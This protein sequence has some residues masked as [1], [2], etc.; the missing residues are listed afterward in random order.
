MNPRRTPHHC[1]IALALAFAYAAPARALPAMQD[2]WRLTCGGKKSA[3]PLDGACKQNGAEKKR[4]EAA[5]AKFQE[6]GGKG[7]PPQ[8]DHRQSLAAV[9]AI[10]QSL[11][12]KVKQSKTDAKANYWL[13]LALGL[14]GDE[15]AVNKLDD[16]I[17]NSKD[18]VL[19]AKAELAMAEFLF[20][21]KGPAAALDGYKKVM[22][23]KDPG[24]ALY[25]RYK[26]AWVDYAT[27]V[28]NKNPALKK[29]ALTSLA[30]V[31][32]DANSGTKKKK[33]KSDDDDEEEDD[34]GGTDPFAT[35]LAKVVKDDILNL[36]I[37]YGNPADVQAI[38]KSVNASD[39]YATFLERAAYVKWEAN[40][41][42]EAYKMFAAAIK[43]QVQ[44][45]KARNVQLNLNLAQIA[46][47]MNNIPLLVQ[48]LKIIQKTFLAGKAPWRKKQKPADLKKVDKQLEGSFF[49]YCAALDQ[50][51][52]KD[53]SP[54]SLAAADELY[55]LFIASFPKSPKAYEARFY[56]G[57]ILFLEKNYLKSAQSLI[58]MINQNPKGKFTKDGLDVM[59][60][61]AQLVTDADK[62]K[63]DVPKMGSIK[64]PRDIPSLRKV[65]A[66]A[67][68]LYVK[69][70]PKT[71]KTPAMKFVAA[72][73]YYDYGHYK[74]AIKTYWA[75]VQTYSADPMAKQAAQRLL[76]YYKLQKNDKGYEKAKTKLAAIRPIGTAPE[77]AYYFAKK[78]KAGKKGKKGKADGSGD[79]EVAGGK[80]SGADTSA[81]DDDD[82]GGKAEPV[83]DKTD[84]PE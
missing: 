5:T 7:N 14:T 77:L 79:T 40:Q 69:M 29:Q 71:E 11:D 61:A 68:E 46:A 38:L 6:A 19:T 32:H 22:K 17:H 12:A 27:G 78:E 65:Y 20:D 23:L 70:T 24:S 8:E 84:E 75:Y 13:G 62:T 18:P 28:Q 81:G 50:S 21:K 73:I 44:A 67:L 63:Y 57:Q 39:V 1:L 34:A 56:D 72:G 49:D 45:K 35:A 58:G 31:S 4:F 42:G 36:S 66:E 25:A 59:V 53:Q 64:K 47:Q 37:D 52:R 33:K 10:A 82:D 55:G 41:Q 51:A 2:Y 74:E 43:E 3:G 54:K 76:E 9:K 80:G 15:W 60:T 26:L 30:R 83:S 48:N 16:A